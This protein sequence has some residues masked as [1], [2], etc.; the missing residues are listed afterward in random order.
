VDPALGQQSLG[1][2]HQQDSRRR[3]REACFADHSSD[4]NSYELIKRNDRESASSR[5]DRFQAGTRQP[6]SAV[7]LAAVLLAV[8]LPAVGGRRGCQRLLRLTGGGEEFQNLEG[9][10][11]GEDRSGVRR[12]PPTDKLGSKLTKPVHDLINVVH[13]IGA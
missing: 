12:T 2:F 1:R 4:V 7:L 5:D 10:N 9:T 3:P 8:D 6:G 11:A 13:A